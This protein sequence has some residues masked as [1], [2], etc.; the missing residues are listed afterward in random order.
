MNPTPVEPTFGLL[1]RMLAAA[2]QAWTTVRAASIERS[3]AEQARAEAAWR[4]RHVK[5]VERHL[6]IVRD[7]AIEAEV[8]ASNAW[9]EAQRATADAQRRVEALGIAVTA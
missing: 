4:E 9:D 8:Q 3:I 1:R 7:L 6:V 5:D 2:W